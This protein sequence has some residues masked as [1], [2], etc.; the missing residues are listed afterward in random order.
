[1]SNFEEVEQDVEELLRKIIR[2]DF[3]NVADAKIKPLYYMKKKMSKGVATLSYIAKTTPILNYLTGSSNGEGEG[4]NY[5][6]FM[7][8]NVFPVLEYSD[9]VRV[10]RHELCHIFIDLESETNPFKMIDH[11]IQDF[12]SEIEHSK[13]DPKWRERIFV[14]AEAVYAKD[15]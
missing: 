15:E 10:I 11:E 14:V 1:M 3:P 4:Y 2:E 9:K 7:D 8:G 12:Y 5:I 13:D 6:L